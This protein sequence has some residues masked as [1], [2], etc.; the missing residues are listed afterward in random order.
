MIAVVVIPLLV[1]LFY[2]SILVDGFKKRINFSSLQKL[3]LRNDD[4]NFFENPFKPNLKPFSL[5]TSFCY[6]NQNNQ[7]FSPSLQ[8]RNMNLHSNRNVDDY[9]NL[10]V[11][12]TND[13]SLS[14]LHT[15]DSSELSTGTNNLT[16]QETELIQDKSTDGKL[17]S[18]ADNSF[19]TRECLIVLSLLFLVSAICALDRVAMSVAII[20]MS[21]D[22]RY[23]ESVKGTISSMFSFGYLFGLL[24]AGILG[25]I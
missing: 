11:D 3:H 10:S 1:N 23:T 2:Y 16:L 7:D 22:L 9:S 20:P 19:L 25:M 24:P 18:E 6:I 4:I 5:A 15:N 8:S 17:Q 21:L 12:I 13:N 14:K